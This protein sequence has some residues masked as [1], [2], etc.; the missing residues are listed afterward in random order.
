MQYI[1]TLRPVL[2]FWCYTYLAL[3]II[4]GRCIDELNGYRCEC[5]IGFQGIHCEENVND[6]LPNALGENPCLNKGKCVDKVNGFECRC[7]PGF[8]G[9]ICQQNI[10]ECQLAPCANG[11][12]C[13]DLVN[14]FT[15]E[16]PTGFSGKDCSFYKDE[17]VSHPCKNGGTCKN[18]VD[19]FDCT[20]PKGYIGK[21]CGDI[22]ISGI[23]V[24]KR[25]PPGV[26]FGQEGS[27]EDI[28]TMT[29]LVLIVCLGVGIPLV[30]LILVA[31]FLLL[32]RRNSPPHDNDSHN[33]ER[34]QNMQNSINNKLTDSTGPIFTTNP[35]SSNMCSSTI[36]NVS[37]VSNVK[38]TNEEKDFN[39]YK[40]NK[41]L[42]KNSN[43]QLLNKELNTERE[44]QQFSKTPPSPVPP[45]LP[46]QKDFNKYCAD[47]SYDTDY[48]C[49][50]SAPVN[51]INR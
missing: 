28:I 44:H 29:H 15:C 32:R 45:S 5:H 48:S 42:E 33:K 19:D 30:L 49:G 47:T 50:S 25:P 38:M 39:T 18:V 4:T 16:C 14:D 13:I 2:F 8:V 35:H 17:C 26:A 46:P 37:N 22:I 31:I 34:E 7:E 41:L 27:E 21:D 43:K 23:V 1:F 40:S 12:K 51:N 6:C 20:C 9:S 11:G 10:D 24:T 3:F 36:S